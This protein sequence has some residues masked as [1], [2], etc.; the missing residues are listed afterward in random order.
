MRIPWLLLISAI[1]GFAADRPNILFL[2]SDDHALQAISAY[3]GRFKDIAP[4]PNI[5]RLAAH[6]GVA[7]E[8]YKLMRFPDTGEWQLFDLQMDPHEMKSVH[9]DPAYRDIL[10]EMKETYRKLKAEYKVP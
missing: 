5:D 10:A 9:D 8:R 7:N 1:T 2:F 3:G 6:D 4:T